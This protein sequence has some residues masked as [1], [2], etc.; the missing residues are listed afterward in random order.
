PD[1]EFSTFKGWE[2]LGAW[3]AEMEKTQIEPSAD[4]KAKVADLTK[5]AKT[6]EDKIRAIYD[7]VAQDY[8]Y[9]SLSFGVGRYQP[10][11]AADIFANK[12]GDCKDKH[13]LLTTMLR[14][15]GF[16]VEPVLISSNRKLDPDV[17]S[18]SQFDHVISYIHT[19]TGDLWADTT[20]EIAP[21][22][23]LTWNIR[24]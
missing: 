8:R 6:D 1:I 13:T 12:Y 5:D 3:F 7:Y 18:P 9:V 19:K 15:A 14:V 21:F 2:E 17:P 22:G 24:K 10:H 20:T 23:M 4:M 11:K 16:S